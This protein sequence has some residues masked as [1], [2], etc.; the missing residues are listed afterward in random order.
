MVGLKFPLSNVK[1]TRVL[2][3]T[4][5]P[6]GLNSLIAANKHRGILQ[7][8]SIIQ[9]FLVLFSWTSILAW[10]YFNISRCVSDSID[11]ISTPP[12]PS[13]ACYL[14][15]VPCQ[16]TDNC[17][18]SIPSS[19]WQAAQSICQVGQCI[20]WSVRRLFTSA[21]LKQWCILGSFMATFFLVFFF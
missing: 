7:K 5:C 16:T 1:R 6:T 3:I 20:S 19:T 8:M 11:L 4:M 18:W 10:E 17:M 12:F 13:G 2:N 15:C 9:Y 14:L 21:C